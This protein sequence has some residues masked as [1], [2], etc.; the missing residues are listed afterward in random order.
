MEIWTSL[1]HKHSTPVF[2]SSNVNVKPLLFL[3]P[4]TTERSRLLVLLRQR[5][6]LCLPIHGKPPAELTQVPGN[7]CVIRHSQPESGHW[8]RLSCPGRGFSPQGTGYLKVDK[9]IHEE[10][11]ISIEFESPWM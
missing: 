1:V 10:N 11:E 5:E 7:K 2:T 3:E 8:P 9:F 6:R 4:D